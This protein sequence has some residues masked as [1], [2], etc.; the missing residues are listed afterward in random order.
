MNSE[1]DFYGCEGYELNEQ[2]EEKNEE[3]NNSEP[4]IWYN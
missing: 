3:Q 1:K 2:N 4:S